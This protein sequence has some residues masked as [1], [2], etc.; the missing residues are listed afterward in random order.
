VH[1]LS[2]RPAG[3]GGWVLLVAVEHWWDG[4]R[5]LLKSITW[6]RVLEGNAKAVLVWMRERETG[7]SRLSPES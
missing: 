4:D 3:A 7:S 5:E 6:A 2:R 1:R